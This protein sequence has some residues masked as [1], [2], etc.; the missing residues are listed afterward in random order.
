MPARTV[1]L[2]FIEWFDNSDHLPLAFSYL[3]PLPDEQ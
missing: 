1:L 3:L 2:V